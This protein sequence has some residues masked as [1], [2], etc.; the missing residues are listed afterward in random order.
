MVLL[1]FDEDSGPEERAGECDVNDLSLLFVVE[2][3]RYKRLGFISSWGFNF[4]L[5]KEVFSISK[6]AEAVL[7]V[8]MQHN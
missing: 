6:T 8:I 7:P 4:N 3:S 5:T 1:G 2:S